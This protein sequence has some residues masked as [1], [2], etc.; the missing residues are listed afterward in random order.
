MS[1][2]NVSDNSQFQNT[3]LKLRKGKALVVNNS[4]D[5]EKKAEHGEAIVLRGSPRFFLILY[6]IFL[7]IIAV[8]VSIWILGF[9]F[10][11]FPTF[12]IVISWWFGTGILFVIGSMFNLIIL[13]LDG[14]LIRRYIFF[15]F[16]GKWKNLTMAPEA[17]VEVGGP[18]GN[19]LY[20]LTF[21]GPWGT[22]RINTRSIGIN[23]IR[24]P[25]ERMNFF[26]GIAQIYYGKSQNK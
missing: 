12:I 6:A 13:D 1:V 5:A 15:K 25:K 14:F 26:A 3:L 21:T 11:H 10:F 23:D 2:K 19:K 7:L 22:R 17:A 4:K 24:K 16:S 20:N 18:Y 8:M 9:N